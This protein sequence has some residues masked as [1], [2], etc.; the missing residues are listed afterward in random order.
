M[1]SLLRVVR[2]SALIALRMTRLPQVPLGSSATGTCP[3][4]LWGLFNAV[5]PSNF[6]RL[7]DIEALAGLEEVLHKMLMRSLHCICCRSKALR[8]AH[9]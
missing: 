2:S 4:C 5:A 6:P 7:G 3:G 8:R 9:S 1:R